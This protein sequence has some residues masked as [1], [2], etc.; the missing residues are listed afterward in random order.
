MKKI[1]IILLLLIF[2]NLLIYGQNY[3]LPLY[4]EEIPNSKPTGSVEKVGIRD[5]IAITNI[6]NPDISVYLPSK[7]YM[8]G[9]AVIICPGGG[10]WVLTYD[11]EGTDIARYLNSIGVAGIVLKYRLPTYGNVTEPHKAL[12]AN[13]IPAELHILSEG[14]HVFGSDLDD[15]R[16]ASSAENLKMWTTGFFRIDLDSNLLYLKLNENK[17]Q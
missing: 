16:I 8:T 4:N 11:L 10:Y 13:R 9:Q 15:N 3:V 1:P 17:S 7:R 5:I 14:N 2:R 6:Q 12:C